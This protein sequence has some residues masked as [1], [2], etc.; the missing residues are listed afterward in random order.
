MTQWYSSKICLD[1]LERENI[2]GIRNCKIVIVDDRRDREIN[3]V[4]KFAR[5]H[6]GEVRDGEGGREGYYRRCVG[7]REN[8]CSL[9]LPIRA[10]RSRFFFFLFYADESVYH[11]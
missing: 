3:C 7:R 11:K 6:D 10:A 4:S 8:F 9:Q 2:G 1:F 5:G